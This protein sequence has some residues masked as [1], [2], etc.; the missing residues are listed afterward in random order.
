ML[1]VVT[2]D[3]GGRIPIGPA[4]KSLGWPPGASPPVAVV[5]EA[6]V[7]GERVGVVAP[8]IVRGTIDARGSL[9]VRAAMRAAV[10][11]EPG[12][13]VAVVTNTRTQTVTI[14]DVSLLRLPDVVVAG[15]SPLRTMSTDDEAVAS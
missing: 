7:V 11:I 14:F 5:G 8:Y 13:R 2:V 10:G 6:L 12:S 3:R 1:D 4:R 9:R 15:T